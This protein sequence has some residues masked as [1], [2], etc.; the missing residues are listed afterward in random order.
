MTYQAPI[1]K[2]G[3]ELRADQNDTLLKDKKTF[4][5]NTHNEIPILLKYARLRV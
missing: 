1:K 2:N 5:N 4:H 3:F